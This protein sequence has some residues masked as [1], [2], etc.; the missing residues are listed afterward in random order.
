MLYYYPK[1]FPRQVDKSKLDS[2]K[3]HKYNAVML[4]SNEGM[5]QVRNGKIYSVHFQ[6]D[7]NSKTIILD[8]LNYVVDKTEIKWTPSEKLPY[9][10]IRKDTSVTCY[11]CGSIKFYIEE[12]NDKVIHMYF[13]IKDEKIYGVHNDI[14]DIMRKVLKASF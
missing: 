9:D 13:F 12:R 6:D 10:F 1:E 7:T 14:Q 2:M 3:F 4:Y 11:E 5:F 8:G